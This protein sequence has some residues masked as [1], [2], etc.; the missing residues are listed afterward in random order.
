MDLYSIFCGNLNGKKKSEINEYM[1]HF[2]VYLKLVQHCK[3]T[4]LNIL[5][6]P[7]WEKKKSEINKYM[8]MYK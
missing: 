5:R 2:A 3:S 1:N 7:K 4:I 6:Q 8:Y